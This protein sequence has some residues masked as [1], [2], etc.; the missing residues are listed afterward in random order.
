L[1]FRISFLPGVSKF[2]GKTLSFDWKKSFIQVFLLKKN[3]YH[4]IMRRND[5][6]SFSA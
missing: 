4:K 3:L 6:F 5:F 1:P 2:P